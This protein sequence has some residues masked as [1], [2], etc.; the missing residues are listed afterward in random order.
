MSVGGVWPKK[1]HREIR[2]GG[3]A[4]LI[5]IIDPAADRDLTPPPPP[6]CTQPQPQLTHPLPLPHSHKYIH[7]LTCLQ[8]CALA[9]CVIACRSVK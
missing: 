4:K 6:P 1:S 9:K 3:K 7:T 2:G 5:E 8:P